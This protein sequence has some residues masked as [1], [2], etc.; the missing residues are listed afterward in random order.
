MNDKD[1]LWKNVLRSSLSATIVF[2]S[3]MSRFDDHYATLIATGMKELKKKAIANYE[4]G[5]EFE[6]MV[7]ELLNVGCLLRDWQPE[8][9]RRYS[10][11][12]DDEKISLGF[13]KNGSP[14]NSDMGIDI[15]AKDVRGWWHAI[16]VKYVKKPRMI[17]RLVPWIVNHDRLNTFRG[18]VY[19]TGP[20]DSPLELGS[21]WKSHVVITNSMGV[22]HVVEKTNK[23]NT[24]AYGTFAAISLEKWKEIL[25]DTGHVL[26]PTND[27]QMLKPQGT[28][29]KVDE[30]NRPPFV[31]KIPKNR[32]VNRNKI[33]QARSSFLDK[34]EAKMDSSN[35]EED[36]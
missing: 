6:K 11:L 7:A 21:R 2:D 22:R 31:L 4:K 8:I 28:P 36:S 26:Q 33:R 1:S 14:V 12:T 32:K 13:S 18:Y 29:L 10:D 27:D 20:V 35:E 23:D 34:L 30:V 17:T 19:A 15:V 16:Q 5:I 25:G 24:V 3:F 9:V